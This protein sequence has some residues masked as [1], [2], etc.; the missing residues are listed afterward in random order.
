M[1]PSVPTTPA[2]GEGWNVYPSAAE[3]V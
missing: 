2:F 3:K 1:K